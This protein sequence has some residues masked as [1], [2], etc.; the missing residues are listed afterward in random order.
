LA[1]SPADV[2]PAVY[3]CTNKIAADHENKVGFPVLTFGIVI[4]IID[5]N[6]M[7]TE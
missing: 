2:L 6:E 5:E 3:L 1:L 7:A 4:F